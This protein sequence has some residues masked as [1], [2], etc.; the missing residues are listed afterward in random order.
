LA[1]LVTDVQPSNAWLEGL[2]GT[3]TP[4]RGVCSLGRASTNQVV[5][6][7][8]K[9]SRRHALIHPQNDGEHWLVDFG[10]T[11]GTLLNG[12]RVTQPTLLRDRDQI[13]IGNHCLTFRTMAP[14]SDLAEGP[15]APDITVCEI[16]TITCWLLVVDIEDSTRFSQSCPPDK[17]PVLLGRWLSSCQE[18]IDSCGGQINKFLGDGFFAYWIENPA[19]VGQVAQAIQRLTEAQ[20]VTEPRFRWALH[21][22]PVSAGG[23][24]SMGEESLL[25][26]EVNF[27]FR[28]EKLAGKLG[29]RRLLSDAAR[30]HIQ[31]PVETREAGWHE[32][33]GFSGPRLF[34][35]C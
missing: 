17:L 13:L 23:A 15:V 34:H 12:R 30:E 14:S 25:G 26:R 2:D 4:I 10:S 22:G 33:G 18:T 20:N 1:N 35:T 31:L 29:L 5:L 6:R 11:N 8:E 24:K 3:A 27:V 9:A 28:M 21:Y 19:T 7:D 16:R 32:V